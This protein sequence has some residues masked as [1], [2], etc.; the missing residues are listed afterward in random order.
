V[1]EVDLA[2]ELYSRLRAGQAADAAALL[3]PEFRATLSTGM[4]A[5]IGRDYHGPDD[6]LRGVYER[7]GELYELGPDVKEMI[8]PADGRVVVL[9]AY[10]GKARS[11]GR[12]INAGFVHILRFKDDAIS[13]LI[14]VTD[15]AEWRQAL[16]ELRDDSPPAVAG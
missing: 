11:T 5:G 1:N 10:V 3:H 16:G 15:T 8:G 9:G 13:E 7:V 6:M 2:N 12:A 4:P 14:Q